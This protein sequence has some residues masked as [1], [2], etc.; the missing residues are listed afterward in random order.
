MCVLPRLNLE[1]ECIVLGRQHDNWLFIH[2]GEQQHVSQAIFRALCSACFL[3]TLPCGLQV[4]G[5][6][7]PVLHDGASDKLHQLCTQ[8]G[9]R[10]EPVNTEVIPFVLEGVGKG[11]NDT[12][13]VPKVMS[14]NE[15]CLLT[16]VYA[17]PLEVACPAVS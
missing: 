8:E 12:C 16:I 15:L 17:Q 3:H 6:S 14:V 13:C 9:T 5:K 10:I 11:A 2:P 1:H 4:F 7:L